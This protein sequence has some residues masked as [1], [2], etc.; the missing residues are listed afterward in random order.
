MRNWLLSDT[1]VHTHFSKVPNSRPCSMPSQLHVAMCENALA[2][3]VRVQCKR[4]HRLAAGLLTLPPW[5]H[6]L[7]HWT[8]NTPDLACFGSLWVVTSTH[9]ILAKI[10]SLI[11]IFHLDHNCC[12][13]NYQKFHTYHKPFFI[14]PVGQRSRSRLE[15]S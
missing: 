11:P 5:H 1:D 4:K 12:I 14:V 9:K 13:T 6:V 15:E 8:L 3:M 7:P 10:Q 2:Q